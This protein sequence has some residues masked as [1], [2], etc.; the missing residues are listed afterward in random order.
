MSAALAAHD[1]LGD[2]L[3][4]LSAQGRPGR[5]RPTHGVTIVR[6]EDGRLHPG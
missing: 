1:V 4:R 3:M 2:P 5:G 6:T